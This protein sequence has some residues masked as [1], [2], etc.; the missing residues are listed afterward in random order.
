LCAVYGVEPKTKPVGNVY[1][2]TNTVN[3]KKYVGR[4]TV[5]LAGR[6]RA[7]NAEA[8]TKARVART[9]AA[10]VR[11]AT[12]SPEEAARRVRLREAC[13]RYNERKREQHAHV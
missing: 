1:L 2:I 11:D 12:S 5:T 6:W 4:T 3:G 13:R 8:L 10:L 9:A 7:R